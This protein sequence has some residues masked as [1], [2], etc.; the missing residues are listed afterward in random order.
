L[1]NQSSPHRTPG[2]WCG[3]TF[4]RKMQ[5]QNPYD[6]AQQIKQDLIELIS[7]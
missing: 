6:L 2:W 7:T 3:E 1:S 4:S 5:Q